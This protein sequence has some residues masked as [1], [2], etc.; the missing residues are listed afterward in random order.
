MCKHLEDP[1]SVNMPKTLQLCK[2]LL[3]TVALEGTIRIFCLERLLTLYSSKPPSIIYY[4]AKSIPCNKK[5]CTEQDFSFHF[6]CHRTCSKHQIKVSN[7]YYDKVWHS[8]FTSCY[9]YNVQHLTNINTNHK[10]TIWLQSQTAAALKEYQR[11]I[12]VRSLC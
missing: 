3:N 8:A 2:Y 11:V 1:E 4:T 9:E 5:D 10:Y 6:F 12:N 7:V